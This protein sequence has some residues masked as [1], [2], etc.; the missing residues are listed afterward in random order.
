VAAVPERSLR[1]LQVNTFDV[2]GGAATVAWSLFTAYR[3]RG[4]RSRLAVGQKRSND[5]DVLE[6]PHPALHGRWS[7]F[8]R[9]Q[10]QRLQQQRGQSRRPLSVGRVARGLAHVLGEPERVLDQFRGVE[11]F[12]FPGSREIMRRAPLEADIVHGH[13]LHGSYFDPRQLPTLSHRVP[14]VLTLH[15]A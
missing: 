4:H 9:E 8:W 2:G 13:N 11:D 3:E 10:H 14:V 7:A 12:H 15:D 5:P 6:V 1:I